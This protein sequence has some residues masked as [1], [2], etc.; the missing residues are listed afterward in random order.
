MSSAQTADLTGTA[1]PLV[2]PRRAR[3][4]LPRTPSGVA[5]AVIVALMVVLAIIGPP[6]WGETAERID[7]SAILQGASS[8]HPLGTD[9]LGRDLL[10]RMLVAG[11]FS[12]T[13]A[14]ISSLIGAS[15]GVVLG[16]LPSVLPRRGARFVTGLVNALVAFPGL[17]LA[18]FT[19]VVTG[20]GAK[21]AVLG[22]GVASAPAFARLTQ[23]LAASVAGADYVSAARMLGVPRRWV[24]TR[25][26]LPNIAEPL[27][28][29]L[30]QSLGFALLGLAGM[31]FLG[32]G[33]QP[34]DFDWGRLLFDGFS[35]IYV[36]PEVALGPALAVALAGIGFNLLGDALAKAA[37][38]PA[39]RAEKPEAVGEEAASEPDPGAVLEVRELTVSFPG[40]VTPVRGLSLSVAPGEIVGIVGESGS[41]KSLTAAA[42]GGLVPHPG[43]VTHARLRLDGKDVAGMSGKELGTTLAMVFQDPMASLN[44]ALKVGGQ[45]AEVATVHLGAGRTEAHARAVDRL[46]HVHLP[47]PDKQARRH[48]HELSGGMR[49][50]AV[51]AMG[52]MG[53]PKLIIA[54][55][56]TTA[57]DVTVQ[58]QILRLLRE[59]VD[60]SGAAALFISHDIAVVGELCDRVVV[61]YAGRV[62]EEL[63]VARLA[64]GAAHP[65]TRALID[66]LPDMDTDRS[67][68]L[69]SIPGRQPAPS[70]VGTGC[71]FADRCELAAARCSAERPPLVVHG[72][73]HQVACW[74]V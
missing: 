51:I 42:I 54:D 11:R 14:L 5:G 17:L 55:E 24:L 29:N 44:P 13:L 32:L 66:S 36:T 9:N 60:E 8:A 56:P 73:A 35:R 1:Q 63:P 49:Q 22:I 59:V 57:L 45:L 10:A 64:V 39:V 70:Q 47:E 52:L 28:L 68:P 34:P 33:V 69:A 58:R 15:V 19:A 43:T 26:V 3:L 74:E 4:R 48:P 30:T 23:T 12:L 18:M 61:M 67:R 41:G 40:G 50:R 31:S 65:Y 37:G 20:L 25:H 62:V 46:G 72:P 71:A 16:A 7:A 38:R 21:G 2:R 6:I 53:E 27:I